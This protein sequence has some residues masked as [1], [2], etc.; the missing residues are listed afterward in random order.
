MLVYLWRRDESGEA[1]ADR[2]VARALRAKC[3]Q[4][5]N[6]KRK[7]YSADERG[8]AKGKVGGQ[9]YI[10]AKGKRSMSIRH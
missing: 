10:H 5:A 9:K 3:F 4:R 6:D 2:H 1:S 7:L 8:H